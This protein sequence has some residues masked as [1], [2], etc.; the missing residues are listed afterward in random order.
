MFEK[1]YDLDFVTNVFREVN[2]L[3]NSNCILYMTL[4]DAL[5]LKTIAAGIVMGAA[6]NAAGLRVT[7]VNN[8]ESEPVRYTQFLVNFTE[9]GFCLISFNYDKNK[10]KEN[11]SGSY[12][13]I[14]NSDIKNIKLEQKAIYFLDTSIWTLTIELVNGNK[15]SFNVNDKDK[16]IKYQ[17]AN[18]NK[19]MTSLG[20]TKNITATKAKN[21][22]KYLFFALLIGLVILF[23]YGVSV[24]LKSSNTNSNSNS[25]KV[26]VD[27]YKPE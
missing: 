2:G 14:N 9:R 26:H 12:V 7:G 17:E 4:E 19:F 8:S 27:I 22:L 24:A 10:D 25:N 23:I 5:D 16:N 20:I 13:F 3:G 15:I 18:F 6:F 1:F 11:V 21:G